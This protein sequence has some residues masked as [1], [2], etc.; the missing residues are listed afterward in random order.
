MPG[1]L[2]GREAPRRYLVLLVAVVTITT[3]TR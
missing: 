3:M 1:L 2:I